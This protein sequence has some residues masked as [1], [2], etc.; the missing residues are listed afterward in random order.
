M[1]KTYLSK[2]GFFFAFICLFFT[3]A[4]AQYATGGAAGE[5]SPIAVNNAAKV[6]V[7]GSA[8]IKILSNDI[9]GSST[10]DL[11]TI[12]I[13]TPPAHGTV[14]VN[15][16]GTVTYAVTPGYAGPDA[17]TYRAKDTFGSYTN[18]ATVTLTATSVV[19][20]TIPTEFTPNGDGINDVFEIRHLDQYAQNQLTIVNRWGNEV[21]KQ[22]NYQNT[23]TGDGLNEGTYYYL[24]KVKATD[25]SDWQ[26]FKGY[27]TLIRTFKK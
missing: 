3:K 24:L 20:L 15:G 17:F 1:A 23:W 2:L 7:N 6:S 5:K 10:L 27:I 8:V 16:D 26:V 9:P 4:S 21:F 25:G 22:I 14:K 11:T 19:D 18:I 13:I 12:E